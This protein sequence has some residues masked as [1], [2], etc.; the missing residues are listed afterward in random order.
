MFYVVAQRCRRGCN[1]DLGNNLIYTHAHQGCRFSPSNS[2]ASDA[3]VA[4]RPTLQGISATC[5]RLGVRQSVGRVGSCF[6]N[7]AAEAFFSTLEH[8]VLS[9]HHFATPANAPRSWS[10]AAWTSTTPAAIA[11]QDYVHPPSSSRAPPTNRLPHNRGGVRRVSVEDPSVPRQ[12]LVPL[13][14][15]RAVR[16][17]WRPIASA[18]R[19]SAVV[20]EW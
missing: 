11:P 18:C 17:P 1:H 19:D 13:P 15:G 7:A 16:G 14:T 3:R 6:D 20:V 10:P 5:V 4:D 2:R 9:R 12:T 8:E